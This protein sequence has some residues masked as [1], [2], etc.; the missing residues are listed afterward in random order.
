MKHLL[1]IIIL[2]CSVLCYSQKKA[3]ITVLEYVEI[4]D[5]NS[6]EALYDFHN[7]WKELR[8]KG[9]GNGDFSEHKIW[10]V[11]KSKNAP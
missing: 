3:E 4:V 11:E 8:K 10:E 7:N 6:S 9:L 5:G 1:L 2:P